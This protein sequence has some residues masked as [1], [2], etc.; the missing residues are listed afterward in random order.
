MDRS[1]KNASCLRHQS[2][3]RKQVYYFIFVAQGRSSLASAKR[4]QTGKIA[5]RKRLYY[6]IVPVVGRVGNCPYQAA[7]E[8][9]GAYEQV[10]PEA[11]GEQ[12]H[13]LVA[14]DA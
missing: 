4:N 12:P 7:H 6:I 14:A 9:H 13:V 3:E 2:C 8:E 11:V 5:T 10:H 1:K